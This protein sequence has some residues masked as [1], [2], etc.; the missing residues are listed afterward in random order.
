M[1]KFPRNMVC[2]D[3]W[4]VPA[5]VH[6]GALRDLHTMRKHYCSLSLLFRRCT[7]GFRTL[8]D[9][10]CAAFVSFAIMVTGLIVVKH[11]GN[12]ERLWKGTESKMGQGRPG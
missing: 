4:L 11:K 8:S 2:A 6:P 1:P 5:C 12:I 9:H 7:D 10:C 3:R